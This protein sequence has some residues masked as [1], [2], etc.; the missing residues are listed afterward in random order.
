MSGAGGGASTFIHCQHLVYVINEPDWTITN[1]GQDMARNTPRA[2][3]DDQAAHES[4]QPGP[5][6]VLAL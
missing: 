6:R 1:S 2:P 5:Y 3:G 4:R